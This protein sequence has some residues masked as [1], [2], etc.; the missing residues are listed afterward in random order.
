MSEPWCEQSSS[1]SGAGGGLCYPPT[2]DSTNIQQV[3][4]TPTIPPLYGDTTDIMKSNNTNMA[5]NPIVSA[6][7]NIFSNCFYSH[8]THDVNGYQED[9][10]QETCGA[11][12]DH[13]YPPDGK[14]FSILNSGL[15]YILH[16]SGQN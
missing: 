8:P 13:G 16:I 10:Q 6:K 2:G 15:E 12:K 14:L 4:Q 9:Q 11:V 3:S 7:L 1:I 5:Q